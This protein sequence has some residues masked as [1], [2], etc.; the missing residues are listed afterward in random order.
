MSKISSNCAWEIEDYIAE[1]PID[2]F[3]TEIEP[4][5]TNPKLENICKYVG[6][7][8]L[9]IKNYA[10]YNK[11]PLN[12]ENIS[13]IDIVD[14]VLASINENGDKPFCIDG[15]GSMG[16]GSYLCNGFYPLSFPDGD[17]DTI[18]MSITSKVRTKVTYRDLLN[19]LKKKSNEFLDQLIKS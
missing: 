12:K 8:V 16:E 4:L 17:V 11:E 3:N 2:K 10:P 1:T 13:K 15:Y 5:I 18:I 14:G 6:H 9:G 19:A 7:R